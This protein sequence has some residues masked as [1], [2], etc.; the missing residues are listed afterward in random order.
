M[1]V[2][3]KIDPDVSSSTM[4]DVSRS[5]RDSINEGY[6]E[7]GSA[8]MLAEAISEELEAMADDNE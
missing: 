8:L 6:F 1:I 2:E 7:N 4:L 3:I 5:L